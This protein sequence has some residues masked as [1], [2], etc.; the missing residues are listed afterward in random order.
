MR[1]SASNRGRS[2]TVRALA[3][4][5]MILGLL[6][7]GRSQ[8]TTV[9]VMSVGYSEAQVVINGSIVRTVR[10]GETTPEGVRLVNIENAAAVFEVDK[11]TLQ[12]ARDSADRERH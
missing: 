1:A 6:I 5:A 3:A 10:I 8:A 9:Y 4:G 2:L 12:R 7:A 11:H